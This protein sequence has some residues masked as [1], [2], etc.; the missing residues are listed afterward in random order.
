MGP[1][2]VPTHLGCATWSRFVVVRLIHLNLSRTNFFDLKTPIYTIPEILV[3]ATVVEIKTHN[4][5]VSRSPPAEIGGG[6]R[7]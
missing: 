2:G 7:Y 3:E 4:Q 1:N 6:K 5:R